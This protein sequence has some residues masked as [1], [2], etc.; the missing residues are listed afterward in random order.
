MVSQVYYELLGMAPGSSMEELKAAYHA[1]AKQNHP[2]LY[3]E[4]ERERYAL[5]MMQINEA[6]MAIACDLAE[7]SGDDNRPDGRYR[8][9]DQHREAAEPETQAVG[10]LK[11]PAYTYYKL[12]FRYFS[13]GR[14][15]FFKRYGPGRRR[16]D[17]TTENIDVLRLA[18]ISLH[19]FHK[20]YVCFQK[21]AHEHATS[22]WAR[23]SE[24]KIYYLNR[25]NVIYQRICNNLSKKI[26]T[27]ERA[28]EQ[29][30]HGN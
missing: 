13:E 29:E 17:F 23:D 24:V 18:A 28:R 15:T 25:Y 14:R 27:D 16:I 1:A 8:E 19:Y 10:P 6:Y 12:G 11:D 20:A 2:D 5:R 30:A 21:V 4:A 7:R 26:A 3:P 9:P 22:V